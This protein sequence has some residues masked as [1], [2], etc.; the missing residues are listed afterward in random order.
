MSSVPA[1]VHSPKKVGVD[2]LIGY[3]V[4]YLCFLYLPI[5]LIPLFSFNDSVYIAFPIESFTLQWYTQMFEEDALHRS[6]FN[7]IKVA[8]CVS[9]ISTI[10]GTLAA[11]AV[12]RYDLKWKGPLI[13]FI[14][15]PFVIPGIILGISLLVLVNRLGMELSLITVGIGHT[16]IA[17]PFSM[18]VMISRLE[19]FEKSLEEASLDL[20]ESGWSTFWRV[21]FPLAI[22]GIVSSLLLTFTLSFDEFL[23]A[24]F[25]TGHESTLPI[26]IFGQLRLPQKLPNVLALGSCILAVSTVVIALAEW[27]RRRS[28]KT[29]AGTGGGIG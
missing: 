19:G 28:Y 14:M 18:M 5:L 27:M 20:G 11:K 22:P 4:F 24:F 23:L 25:L 12:T 13:A 1:T 6:L 7:S 9:V 3:G 8:A 16:M 15:I 17:I 21:T 10:F 2:G 29:D 26:Y